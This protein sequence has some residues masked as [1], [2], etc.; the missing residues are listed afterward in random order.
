MYALIGVLR[1]PADMDTASFRQWWLE[2]HA[3]QARHLPRLRKYVVYPLVQGFDAST[4]EPSGEPS[5]DGVAFLWFDTK[6]DLQAAFASSV[7]KN[8]IE[9]GVTAPIE[10]Q[11][12]CTDGE[13]K[14]PLPDADSD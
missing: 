12:F 1:K 10:Y 14:I 9:H 13:I 3:M 6:E 4:G 11:L 7:G 2:E 8:D 5:Q